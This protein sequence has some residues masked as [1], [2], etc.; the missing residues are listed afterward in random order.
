MS[1]MDC[2][3]R[4]EQSLI[5]LGKKICADMHKAHWSESD[6]IAELLRASKA[7]LFDQTDATVLVQAAEKAYCPDLL[8]NGGGQP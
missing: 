2:G 5:D 3:P 1:R 6:A 4:G 7:K 8:A